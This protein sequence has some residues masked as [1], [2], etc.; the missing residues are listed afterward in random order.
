M[1]RK[2][3]ANA[4][5]LEAIIDRI[6][7]GFV[8]RATLNRHVRMRKK[9]TMDKLLASSRI[10]RD[11]NLFFDTQRL[12][13]EKAREMDNW[14]RPEVPELIK[15]H[16]ISGTTIAER[17]ATREHQMEQSDAPSYVRLIEALRDTPGYAATCAIC[18]MPDDGEVLAD[19]VEVGVLGQRDDL[20][21]D[22]LRLGPGT[23]REVCRRQEILPQKMRLRDLLLARP[24]YTAP[25]QHLKRELGGR[26][27]RDILALGGFQIFD[28]PT[29]V[30]SSTSRWICVDDGDL[31][32]AKKVA[33]QVVASQAEEAWAKSLDHCGDVLRPGMQD[34]GS[35]RA[36]VLARSYT[37]IR[38][39]NR[40]GVKQSTLDRAIAKGM[41]TNFADPEGRNR[42]PAFEVEAAYADPDYL[43]RIAALEVLKAREIAVASGVSY[44][45]VRRR[46][47]KASISRTEPKWGQVRGRWKLPQTLSEFRTIIQTR[48]E[49]R[50]E[51]RAR[52]QR[53]IEEQREA[54]QR[55]RR[56]L[57]ARLVAA[58]PTWKHERR[59]DQKILLHIGPPNSGKTHDALNTLVDAGS[60][61]YLAPLR[62]L[63]FE[64][65]DRLN[66]R[67][68]PCT[69][70]TGEE[71]FSV[72]EARITAATIE[73][74]NPA[75]S[76]HCVIIDEAQMLADADRGWAWTRALMEAQ[77]TEIHVIG[78]PTAQKLIQQLAN[79]AAI[80]VEVVEHTRLAPIGIANNHWPLS[81]LPAH[82]I[83][84]AFSRR[85]VLH[86]KTELER[87]KRRVSVV[88]GSLP[89]EVR[90]RQADRFADG[91]TEICVA[92]DAVGMGLNL[93]ADYVCFFEAEKFDGQK[94]RLLTPGEVQQIGGRAGRYGF[95]TSGE[96]G[97][98]NSHNLRL[99]RRLYNSDPPALTHARVAPSVQDLEIIPGSL[100]EKLV[101]WASLQSIPPSLR[102]V[103]QTADLSERIELA[104][105]L[106]DEEVEK[107]GLAVA[108]QL[109]NAPARQ[110]SRAF[111]YSCAQ[112]ILTDRFLPLPPSPPK[113]V[114]DSDD[115]ETME[116]CIS[117]ADIYLWLSNR[118]EF[119]AYGSDTQQV[120][121]NR[122]DWGMRIDAA[123]LRQIDTARRCPACERPLSL[124]Y[125]FRLCEHCYETQLRNHES[126]PRLR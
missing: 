11:G 96:I 14:C 124:D 60:G 65:F 72:P 33:S 112:A 28:L 29:K 16:I 38:A 13:R 104:K 102:S 59:N 120:A 30:Q 86:L 7:E 68:V 116:I 23:I 2:R 32:E 107:L 54:E 36:R 73:M 12:S 61:W 115:L 69:L 35:S 70:L 8:R 77:A 46:L 117:C 55:R 37:A 92:T 110:R 52:Q 17:L 109:T 121:T 75:H 22:P 126:R 64:V 88:Y 85:M 83:L 1:V 43:E 80:T 48:N 123:L 95:S 122:R 125:R 94:V 5:L 40:L 39:A 41:I 51:E 76:G 20:V 25:Q 74:F 6:P 44:S 47:R 19:L 62:L 21:F 45:T 63:A 4:Q 99:V 106:T 108:V 119:R 58:F 49:E 57:R 89:P 31:K 118:R 91:E 26:V 111:W 50:A 53:L 90:R 87:M 18:M 93:P 103:I 71:H 56:E 105:L 114:R 113:K 10:S 24:G 101:Q 34:R 78:P 100:A 3:E 79:E 97:A 81:R 98:T 9:G 15:G 66:Q 27:L 67:D 84:V 82:T 42:I